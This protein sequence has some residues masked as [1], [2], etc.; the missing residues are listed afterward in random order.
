MKTYTTKSQLRP[1]DVAELPYTESL[2]QA[3]S[4]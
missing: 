2:Q 3:L 1:F 4:T